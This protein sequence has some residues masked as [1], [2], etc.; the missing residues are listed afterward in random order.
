MSG[1][2]ATSVPHRQLSVVR[3]TPS[4]RNTPEEVERALAAIR[5]LA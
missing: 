4:I 1:C 3:L 2:S 5:A